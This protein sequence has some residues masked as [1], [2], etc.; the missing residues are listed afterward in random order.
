M[1][2]G[3]LLH[4]VPLSAEAGAMAIVNQLRLLAR[5]HAKAAESF[6]V[7]GPRP[8]ELVFGFAGGEANIEVTFGRRRK[9]RLPCYP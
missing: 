3:R 5:L 4:D 8:I 2:L 6:L 1:L 7:F 9:E